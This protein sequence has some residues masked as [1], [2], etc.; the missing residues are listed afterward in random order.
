M[1]EL[2]KQHLEWDE[3]LPKELSTAWTAIVK[4]MEGATQTKLPR[5]YFQHSKLNLGNMQ[6]HVFTDA[7]TKAYGTVAYLSNGNQTSL[8]IS[9][10]RVAPLKQLTLPQLEL[11]AALTAA[12]SANFVTKSLQR[13]CSNLDIHM[14]SD[15]KIVLHWLNSNRTLKQFVANRIEEIKQL[16]HPTHWNYCPTKSNQQ[17]YS[18]AVS[19]HSSSNHHPCG[20]MARNGC[21]AKHAGHLGAQQVF[22]TFPTSTWS[23]QSLWWKPQHPRRRLFQAYI[24]LSTFPDTAH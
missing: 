13:R 6:L 16:V 4:E 1:Q 2:W 9:K 8:V 14:W 23:T 5:R 3:P 20:G 19:V 24:M 18:P 7:S 15:S 22:S 21:S 17:I 12:R 11:M 10:S